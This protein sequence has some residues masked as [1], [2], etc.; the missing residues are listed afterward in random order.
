MSS[1]TPNE[2]DVVIVGGG[3]AGLAVACFVAALRPEW[4]IQ[5]LAGARV[6]GA[7]LLLS[8]GGRCNL[9]HCAVNEADFN[10]A[11]A[12][13][14]RRVL[15]AFPVS[16][17]LAFFREIGVVVR[18]ERDGRVFPT[19]ERARDVRDAL[20]AA[21][22]ARGVHV[23]SGARVTA[24]AR[25]AQGFVV[26]TAQAGTCAA[27][28]VVVA[29]GGRSYPQT[30][31]DGTGYALVRGLGHAIVTPTPALVPL[32]LEG[33]FHRRLS[34]V[35]HPAALRVRTSAGRPA[36]LTGALL[37]THFG[38]SGPVVLDGSR[39]WLRARL[40][41][42][43]DPISLSFCPDEDEASL[44]RRLLA[45]AAARPRLLVTTALSE[46]LP[47][48]LVDALLAELQ[49]PGTRP[50]SQLPRES[51]RRLV[52]ALCEWPLCVRDS[53]GWD[54]AEV[55]AGGVPL[56]EIDCATMESRR[57]TG[58]YLAGEILDVDGRVGGFNLQWAWSS[59]FVAARGVTAG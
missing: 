19:S 15:S 54:V 59:A 53:R 11:P 35:S 48:T 51:R 5:L 33:T 49:I 16:R 17:T 50:V 52:R 45:T 39:H 23:D 9:T 41:G 37:W 44:E 46:Q 43:S 38:V 47:R 13:L 36:R 55:T 40:E 18:E 20:V 4:R 32:V 6:L 34:G 26:E 31:S 42:R 12:R 30:G 25:K 10:G 24:I 57:C 28:R 56:D 29:T 22:R 14:V 3:A 1:S 58:L 8:G 27:L 21:V 7:K 2:S